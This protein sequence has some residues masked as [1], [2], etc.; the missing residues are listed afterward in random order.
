VH[1]KIQQYQ[2]DVVT[3]KEMTHKEGNDTL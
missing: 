1:I 3:K 2:N